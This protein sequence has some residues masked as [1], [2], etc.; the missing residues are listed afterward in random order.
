MFT[1]LLLSKPLSPTSWSLPGAE[2]TA[3]HAIAEDKCWCG[4]LLVCAP[5]STCQPWEPPGLPWGHRE[6]LRPCC[7]AP[8]EAQFNIL[9]CRAAFTTCSCGAKEAHGPWHTEAIVGQRELWGFWSDRRERAELHW[10]GEGDWGFFLYPPGYFG[11]LSLVN[12]NSSS[13]VMGE[14]AGIN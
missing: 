2:E 13:T 10:A 11:P 3:N 5:R 14:W 4:K 1:E 9:S 6:H 7:A 12:H 8:Q